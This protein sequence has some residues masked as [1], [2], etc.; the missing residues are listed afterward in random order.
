MGHD[1]AL[2]LKGAFDVSGFVDR[3]EMIL[4]LQSHDE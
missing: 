4:A 1:P 2:I 3:K